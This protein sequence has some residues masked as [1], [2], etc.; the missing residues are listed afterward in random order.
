MKF[1]FLVL[2]T[3]FLIMSSFQFIFENG[4]FLYFIYFVFILNPILRQ[5][6]IKPF[7]YVVF[8][9]GFIKP[10]FDFIF[11]GKPTMFCRR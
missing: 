10:F 7:R 5:D 4:E 8:G 2:F 9:I 1:I 3:L 6:C 11:G